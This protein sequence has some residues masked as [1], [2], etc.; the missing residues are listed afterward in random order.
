MKSWYNK[1]RYLS[2][3]KAVHRKLP[4]NFDIL[5]EYWKDI[6]LKINDYKEPDIRLLEGM[7]VITDIDGVIWLSPNRYCLD[8]HEYSEI[9]AIMQRI[10]RWP[11]YTEFFSKPRFAAGKLYRRVKQIFDGV[12]YESLLTQ[13]NVLYFSDSRATGNFYHWMIESLSRLLLV[14]PFVKESYLM[15][16]EKQMN[17]DYVI[18]S[19][20]YLGFREERLILIKKG[21]RYR[22]NNLQ[23]VTCSMFA[24]GAC[25]SNG[26]SLIQDKF[27]LITQEKAEISLYIAR[28]PELGRSIVNQNEFIE[29]LKDY[30]IKTIY[31]EDYSFE[32]ITALL[33]KTKLLIAVYSAALTH[34]IFMPKGGHIIELASTKFIEFTP[35]YWD[36]KYLSV[37]AGYYYYSLST[38]CGLGYHL[39]PCTQKNENEYVLSA[40]IYVDIDILENSLNIISNIK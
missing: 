35:S 14:E 40:D 20:K 33:S 28:K 27:C 31:A 13:S 39:V 24:T 15:L 37:Y 5:P 22:V 16:T 8:H 10:V 25:S 1:E 30:N 9:Q 29:V 36:R 34:A 18:G 11:N 26:V 7:D 38:A 17:C 4:I 32:E 19:L 12:K 3:Y 21:I 23:V 2:K 6:F